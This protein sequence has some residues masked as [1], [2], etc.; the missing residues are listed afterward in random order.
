MKILIDTQACGNALECR[1]CLDRCPEKVFGTYA[2]RPKLSGTPAGD[3]IITPL[4]ISQCTGCLECVTFCPRKAIT[5][6]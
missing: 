5:V 6:C 1:L 2:R 4:F 3:W